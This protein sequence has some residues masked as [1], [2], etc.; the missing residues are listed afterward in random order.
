MNK[1][2]AV[3]RAILPWSVLAIAVIA[4]PAAVAQEAPRSFAASP[5]VYKVIAEN[6]KYRIIAAS[7]A[8]GQRDQPHSH[9][10]L[11][12]YF[13]TDCNLRFHHEDGKTGEPKLKAGAAGAQKPVRTHWVENTGNTECRM[14]IFEEK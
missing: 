14:V 3:A 10:S 13:L 5:E 1:T 6:D 9:T 2:Q 4:T 8:P 11:G 12:A 7:W